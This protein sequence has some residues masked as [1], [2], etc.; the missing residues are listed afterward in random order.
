MALDYLKK[1]FN[2]TQ[3]SKRYVL[4]SSKELNVP[5]APKTK[6][7]VMGTEHLVSIV[8]ISGIFHQVNSDVNKILQLLKKFKNS[9]I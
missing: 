4:R 5:E 3:C 2:F 1:K 7:L 8:H 9:V 6:L